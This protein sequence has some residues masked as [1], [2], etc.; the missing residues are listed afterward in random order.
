[1]RRR[2]L[3]TGRLSRNRAQARIEGVPTILALHV[4][5]TAQTAHLPTLRLIAGNPQSSSLA[6]G[7]STPQLGPQ[8]R[9]TFFDADDPVG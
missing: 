6:T 1:M 2:L 8:S 5:G 4:V 9:D 3:N 7:F